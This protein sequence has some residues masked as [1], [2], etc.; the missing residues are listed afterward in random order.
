MAKTISKKVKS[1]DEAELIGLFNLNRLVGNTEHPLMAEWANI[2]I[3]GCEVIGKHWNFVIFE[4]RTY[5]TSK[6]YDSTKSDDLLQIISIL[7]KFKS[8]LEAR[9]TK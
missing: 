6:S 1:Y 9:I 2:P 4:Q 5:C 8:L 7:R 3:Y